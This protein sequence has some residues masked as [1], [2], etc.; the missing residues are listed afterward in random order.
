MLSVGYT[1]QLC[2]RTKLVGMMQ[3]SFGW[4]NSGKAGWNTTVDQ[5]IDLFGKGDTVGCGIAFN[6]FNQRKV[7]L[8][9][10][11]QFKGFINKTVATGMDCFPSLGFLGQNITVRFN[12]GANDFAWDIQKWPKHQKRCYMDSLPAETIHLIVEVRI[13]PCNYSTSY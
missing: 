6:S 5:I 9:L 4:Q 12:F 3:N 2:D 7:F 8:T 11:G 10:N 13:G 1:D